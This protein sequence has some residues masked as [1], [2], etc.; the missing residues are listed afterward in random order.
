MKIFNKKANLKIEC[1]ITPIKRDFVPKKKDGWAFNWQKVYRERPETLFMMIEIQSKKI[2]GV[3]QLIE[4]DGMLIM[5]LIE[6]APFNIGSKKENE[7]V[8]G[9]MIAFGCKE[10]IKLQNAYKGY[11]T[12]ISKTSLIE[13]YTTKYYATQ[14][15]GTRMYIDPISGEKLIKKYLQE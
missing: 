14:T 13:L 1:Q 10:S 11:L 7:H 4:D 12:F 8:A 3:I 2:H 15:I 5:E 6:L 9:C